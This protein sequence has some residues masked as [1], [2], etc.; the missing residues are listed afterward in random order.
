MDEELRKKHAHRQLVRMHRQRRQRLAH[1]D[2]AETLEGRLQTIVEIHLHQCE[3][4]EQ[5]SAH[6]ATRRGRHANHE[7][8]APM[9]GREHVD[10]QRAITIF[11]RP[12]HH[13]LGTRNRHSFHFLDRKITTKE[14]KT[15]EKMQKK[16]KKALLWKKRPIK[17]A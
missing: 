1:A 7:R 15:Q 8:H 5:L 13:G 9:E 16:D 2:V 17:F 6:A 14:R 4:D 3:R 12:Q 10:N 11:H